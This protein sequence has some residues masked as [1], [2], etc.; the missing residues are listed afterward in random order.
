[1]LQKLFDLSYLGHYYR[2]GCFKASHHFWILHII[3]NL[4]HIVRVY[5]LVSVQ[6]I[7]CYCCSL[8]KNCFLEIFQKKTKTSPPHLDVKK[9]PKKVS[10][11]FDII[12]NLC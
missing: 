5:R 7:H 12:S 8:N 2:S 1:M 6:S 3:T 9:T 11:F 10:Q 4:P